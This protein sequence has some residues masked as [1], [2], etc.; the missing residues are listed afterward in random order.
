MTGKKY[1][2]NIFDRRTAVIDPTQVFY[3]VWRMRIAR[4]PGKVGD[5]TLWRFQSFAVSQWD[6]D[7]W[8]VQ[9]S[10]LERI[11]WRVSSWGLISFNPTCFR[12]SAFAAQ[13]LLY[14]FLRKT[15]L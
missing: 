11:E 3:T 4:L 9:M 6:C 7:A 5:E 12:F 13:R 1:E 14:Y 15:C 8:A 2:M 10:V